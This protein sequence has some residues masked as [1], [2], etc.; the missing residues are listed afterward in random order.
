MQYSL[1]FLKQSCRALFILGACYI[2]FVLSCNSLS[3]S[4][5]I[6]G[7]VKYSIIERISVPMNKF[8]IA[9][10]GLLGGYN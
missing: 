6:T 9:I 8:Q 10:C 3:V 5:V 1:I 7:I 4:N 2:C